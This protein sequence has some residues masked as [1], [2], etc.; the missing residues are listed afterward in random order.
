[1]GQIDLTNP[2]LIARS[3]RTMII[4]SGDDRGN[5]MTGA[6]L[7]TP[8]EGYSEVK[9]LQVHLKFMYYIEDVDPPEP[10]SEPA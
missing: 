4:V 8:G 1:M 7:W 6:Q 2:L 3:G 10:W 9:P 5:P